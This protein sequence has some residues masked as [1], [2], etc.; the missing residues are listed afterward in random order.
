MDLDIAAFRAAFT[1]YADDTAYPDS[2]LETKYTIG[3]CYIEDVSTVIPDDCRQIAYQM[4]VAHLLYLDGQIA[5]GN[6]G[7][8]ISSATEGPVSVSF[9]DP[10]NDDNFTLWLQNSP[11]GPQLAA[12][13]ETYEIGDYYGGG[14]SLYGLP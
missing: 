1:A 3:K 10:P 2:L 9:V 6:A 7:R 14:L 8:A 12:L 5:A 11:Y 13:L 4:L